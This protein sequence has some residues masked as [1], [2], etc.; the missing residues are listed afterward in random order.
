MLA[1]GQGIETVVL[2]SVKERH[3]GLWEQKGVSENLCNGI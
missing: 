3:Q 2:S 1:L